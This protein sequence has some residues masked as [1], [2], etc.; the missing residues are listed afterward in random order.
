[1]RGY[2][3]MA[4][5]CPFEGTT[6]PARVDDAVAAMIGAG[7]D[8]II[9]ADTIGIGEPAQVRSL[10][11]AALEH[12]PA[13][14]LGLHMHDTHGRAAANCAVGV[15]MGMELMDAAVGGCGGCPFAPGSAG[16]LAT[17]DLLGVLDQA[18]VP[19][20]V[21]PSALLAANRELGTALGRTL[22]Q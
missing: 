11:G 9:L 15:E 3:S 16:N 1:M 5:G 14:R 4:F 12:V 10:G 6:D 2:A 18:G 17:E 19:H 7:A 21:E 20:G 13:A 22:V 8:A